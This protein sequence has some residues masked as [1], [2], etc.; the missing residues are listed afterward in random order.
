MQRVPL[1]AYKF[2][3]LPSTQLGRIC[4]PPCGRAWQRAGHSPGSAQPQ[5]GFSQ[6]CRCSWPCRQTDFAPPCQTSTA[7]QPVAL[8]TGAPSTSCTPSTR[9]TKPHLIFTGISPPRQVLRLPL[10]FHS[11]PLA[12]H[13]TSG[14][15]KKCCCVKRNGCFPP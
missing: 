2:S 7:Q 10:Q 6:I 5:L 3:F 8:G 14:I 11:D 13:V 12:L 9:G 1:I 4:F 15:K